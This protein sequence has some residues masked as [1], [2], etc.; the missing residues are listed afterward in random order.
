MKLLFALEMVRVERFQPPV[1]GRMPGRT[2]KHH[3]TLA[4]AFLAKM[5]F[6]IATTTALVERLRSDTTLRRLCGWHWGRDVPSESTFSRAF[7]EFAETELPDRLHATL[8]EEGYSE[9]S[10]G[11][12]IRV[13]RRPKRPER[14]QRGRMRGRRG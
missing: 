4:R 9:Q 6:N 1:Q 8:I 7:K 2:L 14:S 13:I 10:V 11:H 3:L 5:V 12:S